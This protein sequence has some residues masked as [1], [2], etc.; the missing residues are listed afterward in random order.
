M[1]EVRRA[2]EQWEP[3]FR[4]GVEGFWVGL[5]NHTERF[6]AGLFD[7]EEPNQ[8]MTQA[9]IQRDQE[10]CAAALK[11]FIAAV[12]A[13]YLGT[14]AGNVLRILEQEKEQDLKPRR[15]K[16]RI[17]RQDSPAFRKAYEVASSLLAD[18]FAER[19]YDPATGLQPLVELLSN[20]FLSP[21]GT[22]HVP[23]L[24][25]FILESKTVPFWWDVM[26]TI[27]QNKPLIKGVPDRKELVNWQMEYEAGL[28]P[29]PPEIKKPAHRHRGLDYLIRDIKA[30]YTVDTLAKRGFPPTGENGGCQ[31]VADQLILSE[32]FV[33]NRIWNN[34]T[35]P[36]AMVQK[37][38]E[39]TIAGIYPQ[40][41]L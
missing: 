2:L 19:L 35:P 18:P 11:G 20:A 13:G 32:S 37:Y 1:R 7:L 22:Y 3:L 23:T 15:R 25:D 39:S 16:Y 12:Q 14:P 9:V 33:R 34:G 24:K 30:W 10:A 29:R 17:Y 28:R 40:H 8:A 36:W 6:V 5:T 31:I 26:W 4:I 41:R 21:L 38:V 27:C